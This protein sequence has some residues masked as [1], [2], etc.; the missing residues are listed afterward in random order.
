MQAKTL[1]R[2]RSGLRWKLS[3]SLLGLKCV[4]IFLSLLSV[5]HPIL[6]RVFTSRNYINYFDRQLIHSI[7]IKCW[8]TIVLL[9][10]IY[11]PN[12]DCIPMDT[13]CL[14]PHWRVSEIHFYNIVPCFTLSLRSTG[15]SNSC[16]RCGDYLAK[17][18]LGCLHLFADSFPSVMC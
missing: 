9:P 13:F 4:S 12:A 18:G 3:G 15:I 1:S 6:S 2:T 10:A 5:A 14:K 8:C 16:S 11:P 17:L 7:S